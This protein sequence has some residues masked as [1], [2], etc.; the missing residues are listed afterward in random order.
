MTPPSWATVFT[1]WQPS[2][3]VDAL[4]VAAAVLYALGV[5]RFPGVWPAR[6]SVAFG[7]A[8]AGLVLTFDSGVAEFG[9]GVFAVHMI[10]HLM[11][12]MVVPSLL[13]AGQPLRL[14]RDA[15]GPERWDRAI[16]GRVV[17]GLTFP[18]TVL[19]VYTLV[20]VLTHL[21][22]FMETMAGSMT[23]HRLEQ[24]LYL[25]AGYLFFLTA[26]GVDA[27]PHR[28]SYFAR[29]VLMLV[30]MGVDTLVGVVL[31]LSPHSPFPSYALDDVHLGGAIMWAG[32]DG[33]MM[34]TMVLLGRVWVQD[35]SGRVDFG[36]WLESARMAAFR[37][38]TG[39]DEP[40]APRGTGPSGPD[41][42]LDA[43]DEALA[44]YNRMLARLQQGERH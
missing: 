31:M 44:A 41:P 8:L 39:G 6:R 35:P 32:G 42:D 30:G 36:P 12:I 3:L 33:L 1:T 5:R 26:L 17:R 14:L 22:G 13:V 25:V 10:M 28:P 21:T 29:Y 19:A 37:E 27:G 20:V 11:L 15:T 23:L 34:I 4:V 18:L 2:W 16:A 7:A 40:G 38:Q 43:D 9:H 24:V